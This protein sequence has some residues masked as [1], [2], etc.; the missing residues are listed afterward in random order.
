MREITVGRAHVPYR[1]M[2]E[3]RPLVLVHGGSP[4]SKAWD[5][6][7][8]AFTGTS[9]V[10][11]PDLSGSDAARDDGGELTVELLV[12][13]LTAVISDLGKGPADVVGHSMGA[14][15]AAALAAVRPDLVRSVV[16]VTGWAGRG[17]E[18]LRNAFTVWRDLAGDGDTFARYTMLIAFSR[19]H[20][21]AIGPAAVAEL[22]T[23]FRP[24]PGRL[25][26]ID[27]ASRL[28]VRDLLPGIQAPTLVIGCARDTLISAEYSRALAADIP[29]A[30]YEEV[31]SGHIVMAERP[32]EFVKLVR[33][34]IHPG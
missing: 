13:Q 33:D 11:L 1:V 24:H 7:A 6:V 32:T 2:G 9:T 3:G 12:E 21:A 27:L 4:G 15:V 5:G 19:E 30:S 26:Q 20:L 28:D 25:R 16:S 31:D 23:A 18:Y 17:D 10:V 29:G 34:F 22:A 8:G 14:S